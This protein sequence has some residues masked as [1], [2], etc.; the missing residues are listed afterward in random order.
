VATLGVAGQSVVGDRFPRCGA[1][2]ELTD[3]RSDPGIVVEGSHPDA[4]RVGVTGIAADQRGTTVAAEAFLAA[5][6]GF[7]GSLDLEPDGPAVAATRERE[8]IH[9]DVCL[10]RSVPATSKNTTAASRTTRIARDD[11]QELAGTLTSEGSGRL[12]KPL[13]SCF[14]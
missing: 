12:L 8:V 1:G 10:P 9:L 13:L 3:A 4:D 7:R 6:V 2:R 11:Q 14:C 5:V